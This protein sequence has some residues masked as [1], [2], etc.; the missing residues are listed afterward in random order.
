MKKSQQLKKR[1]LSLMKFTF[2]QLLLTTLFAGF[3]FAADLSGQEL[4]DKKISANFNNTKLKDALPQ[5][6]QLANISFVYSSKAI[7][8]KR[9]IS[10]QV[11]NQ[12]LSDFLYKL[13]S[14]LNINY[15]E[16]NGQILLSAG[17]AKATQKLATKL[18][19][20]RFL[21]KPTA[22]ITGKVIDVDGE[23]LIGAN[24][25]VKGTSTGTVTDF[26]G[27]YEL[28]IPDDATILVFSYTGYQDK[29]VAID[30]RTVINVTLSEGVELE[31]ITVVG[32]RGKPRTDVERPVPVDV[33]S[34]K[35]LKAT[36]QTDLGQQVQFS[37]PS[38]NSAK[39][40]VNGTTNYADPASLR[41]MGP[42]QSLVLVN[43]KRRHQFSTL[44]LNVAPGLGNVVTDLNSIPSAALKRVEVLRDGA[45]AQYGSDAIAGIIN[46]AL[47]DQVNKGTF[48]STAG[49]HMTA[50]SDDASGG[51]KFRDGVTY[52]NSLNYGFELGKKG[53]FLNI[54]LEQFR[55]SGTN[56]SDY[57]SGT[58]YPS[59]P[60]DQPK[61]AN[62]AIIPTED[63]PYF[64][65]DPRGERGV[66]PQDDF[67]VGNY[68][69]NENDTKQ[70][71]ANFKYPIG[72]NG[73]S[74][75]AFGGY[76]EKDITAFGF[77]RNPGR[78]SRA[79]LTVF[80]DGYVPV[81]PGEGIDYSYA[82][83][84]NR[85]LKDSW[86]FDLSYSKGHNHLDLFNNNSTNPSLGSATPTEFY[87]GRYWFEQDIINGDISKNLGAVGGLAGL[88][89]AFGAQFRN[90]RYQQFIGSPESF[91]VGPLAATKGKD[92]G[93]SAR[94]GI[95]DNNDLDRSN[96]GVYADI[97]ADLTDNFLLTAALRFENYSDF[98][99]NLSGK[100]AARYKLTEQVSVRGSYNR[101]FR[102]PSVAQ[103]GTVN[104]TSTVQ[105]GQ[106]VITRQ[107]P[108]SDPRLAQLGIEDP[109]AEISNNFNVGLTAKLANGAFLITVDAYQITIDERIVI[110][111]RLRTDRYPAVAALFPNE[112]EIRFFT[113]HVDTKTQG[114]D[115]V[116]AYK[117]AFDIGHS[118][119]V[120][121]AATFNGTDVTGQKDTPAE[122]LAGATEANQGLKLLGQVATELIEVAVPRQKILL[123]G[124][125]VNGD[126]G[127]SGRV[128]RF[129]EVKA[130][131]RGLD[132][133]DRNVECEGSRCVQTFD[134]KAVVDL[135]LTR[136]FSEA[137]SLTLGANNIFDT[138]PD[139]Y[140]TSRNGFVGTASSYASGQ[141]PYSRNSNQF[142][143]NGRYLFLTGTIDF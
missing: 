24:I 72:D 20:I 34:A 18:N 48:Q 76:S 92:V 8:A 62:G 138:Y 7:K 111:E 22:T 81:L 109:K 14:P 40:G 69:S 143:F 132:G 116:A 121:L 130:F 45:A 79:V 25:V 43:G 33:V 140:N 13:F 60:E 95:Q 134:A 70:A 80:P 113:N 31:S 46:L 133:A 114:I 99:G 89:L 68:G 49:F 3:S 44:N 39:Y 36:G 67:V 139:K 41:G 37:S 129:G 42:D 123:S 85:T 56:R 2:I 63:Y 137:F 101:G 142:G 110:S 71:F 64:T 29:E 75:Y 120:S 15:K 54:T 84:L 52:K 107:V 12:K 124:Q 5:I 135:S 100:L 90:D 73:L 96:F 27:N 35:E 74:V 127:L 26:D 4:M 47:K 16:L 21:Q 65:E 82:F 19:P 83:G 87:V 141:I 136:K 10:I 9:K 106:I 103:L 117:K 112:R 128:T 30:G 77:F 105:N 66:Y 28:N 55:F 1:L 91:E 93:S 131:S 23:G 38:F 50:P 122:I 94:P 119:N 17:K 6:E 102:A 61:D 32:S 108:S 126:W 86:N 97:E 57:Y 51:R 125:Y 118:L 78:F 11:Q 88:N 53:S 104:N 58:I 98:G 115:I 59:V